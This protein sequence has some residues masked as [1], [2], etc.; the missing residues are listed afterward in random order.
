MKPLLHFLKTTM[1]GGLLLLLPAIVVAILA[2][3]L[4]DLLFKLLEPVQNWLPGATALGVE[5]PY[6]VA[7]LTM[8][9]V[10]FIAGLLGRTALGGR[11]TSAL[12]HAIL[13]RLPG[14][15]IIRSM[16]AGTLPTRTPVEV[17]LVEIE[18]M[19]VIGFIMERHA[20]GFITLFV[21]SAPTPNAGNVYF[22]QAE[23]VRVIDIG[24]K[25]A[26][27]CVSRLGTGG[28]IAR[29]LSE[30]AAHRAG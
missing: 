13:D 23:H 21:P 26:L 22:T 29:L 11:I 25:E 27:R 28:A 15:T 2:R 5:A 8:L 9:L 30:E 7:A 10:C 17:A 19:L 4:F 20:N 14:Y 24:I 16:F 1:F 12:E 6:M 18:N 3:R